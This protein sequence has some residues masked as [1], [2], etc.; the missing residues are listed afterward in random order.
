MRRLL[1]TLILLAALGAAGFH[2]LTRP[3][4]VAAAALPDHTPDAEAGARIFA[5]GGCASCHAAPGAEGDEML[6]L[7]G[8]RK[9]RTGFGT[10]VA[11][12]I[13]PDPDQGI[14]GWTDAEFVTALTRGTSPEG[15]H[16]YPAFP[17]ASYTRMRMEDLMDLHAYIRT[18]P[19]SGAPDRP[20]ELAFP[21]SVRR[22]VGL[23]KLVNLDPS[24]VM[25]DP[26][27]AQ[28]ERGRYLVEGPGHCGECHTPRD[29]TGGLRRN[30]W[31][32]G[33]P[34]PEGKGT[35]PNITPS[36][37]GIGGWSAKDIAYYLE[38]GFTP[39]FDSVG[40][41]MAEVVE[42]LA[43]LPEADR[44]AIAAYLKATPP[45]AGG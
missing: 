25:A 27:D 22:G 19:R 13:S 42:N 36:E 43:T 39:D 17:Y 31:L 20:H 9:L 4:V 21:Y 10:F 44:A 5:A 40:G 8:G 37:D 30:D 33:A 2:W 3:E 18:L 24:W 7:T 29:V 38:T 12:N 45:H 16:Y 32:A 11:P 23:W 15:E 41:L 35:I 1:L 34:N 26:S 6:V 28:V 14:G